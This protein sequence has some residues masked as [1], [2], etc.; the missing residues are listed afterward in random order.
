M[1]KSLIVSA[2]AVTLI[3]LG[4]CHTQATK[5][6]KSAAPVSDKAQLAAKAAINKAKMAQK[7]AKAVNNEWRDTGKMSK[8]AE[9]LVAKGK[10]SEAMKQAGKAENQGLNAVMQAKE[11]A[12]IGNPSYLY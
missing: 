5:S 12:G 6:A 1:K 9:S 11:Q 4:G 10:Y 8:K 2:M 3:T 7:A